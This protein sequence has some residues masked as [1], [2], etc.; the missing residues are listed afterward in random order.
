MRYWANTADFAGLG[1]S[2]LGSA[3]QWAKVA[4][5][6]A[7]VLFAGVRAAAAQAPPADAP[8]HDPKACAPGS[9]A[10]VSP[11]DTPQP[12]TPDA[13]TGSGNL[14]EKLARGNGVLCPPNVDPE[15]KAPTPE[16]GKMPVIPPPGTPGGN[17]NV[18]PK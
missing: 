13:T 5:I 11:P 2:E 12:K 18:N 14:S 15:I 1:R 8:A 9:G 3:H 7:V 17:P 16:A 10:H 4:I 6:V